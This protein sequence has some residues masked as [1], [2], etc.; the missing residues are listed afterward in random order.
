MADHP[1]SGIGIPGQL[2][3]PDK[4]RLCRSANESGHRPPA[5]KVG[6]FCSLFGRSGPDGLGLDE[7]GN[8]FVAHASLGH[9]FVFAPNGECVARIKSYAG[10]TCTNVAFG[11]SDRRHLFITGPPPARLSLPKPRS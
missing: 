8:L 11:G 1:I 7:S 10:T 3:R 6:R 2:S 5:A 4:R 9:V